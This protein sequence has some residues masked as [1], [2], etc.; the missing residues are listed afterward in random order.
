MTNTDGR[1]LGSDEAE[2][3]PFKTLTSDEAKVLKAKLPMVSPWRVVAMQALMGLLCI[4]VVWG[5]TRSD[6]STWSALYGV[7]AV[8]V[9]G[10]LMARGMTKRATNPAAA[11]VGFM[12]WELVKIAVAVA[13]LV[14]VAVAA[15]DVNWLALLAG[16]IV[17]TKASWL[18]LLHKKRGPPVVT[19]IQTTRV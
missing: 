4:L 13:M 3:A 10:A 18:V 8:V 16:M 11:A 12:F 14:A 15:H 19:E 7:A 9:P 5:V 6:A 2:E 1:A 17:S